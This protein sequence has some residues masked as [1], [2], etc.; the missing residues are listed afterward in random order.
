MMGY[1]KGALL[2]LSRALHPLESAHTL[3]RVL[4][5][6]YIG[7]GPPQNPLTLELSVLQNHEQ[8]TLIMSA[9]ER[10]KQGEPIQY[11]VGYGDFYKHRFRVNPT[12]L[13]PRPETEELVLRALEHMSEEGI[14]LD[15]CT[16]SG[17]IAISIAL[18]K[19]EWDVWA[20]E[21]D[22]Q[23]LQTAMLN[24]TELGADRVYFI[25]HNLLGSALNIKPGSAN[26]IV[27]NPPYIALEEAQQM[28]DQVLQYE[29]HIAL[30]AG[31]DPLIFYRK[32]LENARIL[33]SKGGI[34]LCEIN[35]HYASELNI[36]AG[37]YGMQGQ[38]ECDMSGKERFWKVIH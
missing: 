25:H 14:A 36:L 9:V 35:P 22:P 16:G 23:T 28:S 3:A 21:L 38:I 5:E 10:L 33:L 19:P 29:P 4:L 34:M 37:R 32:L 6:E 27:S 20:T 2:F 17:C 7:S 8:Y 18:E 24:A 11:I 15:F 12:C 1:E 30:F 13:V 26:L 31:P